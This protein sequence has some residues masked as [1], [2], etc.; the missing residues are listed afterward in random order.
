MVQLTQIADDAPYE[1]K[2]AYELDVELDVEDETLL[3]RVRALQDIIPPSTRLLLYN[4]FASA[5]SYVRSTVATG[6]LYL[7]TVGASVL[8]VGM[9]WAIAIMAE[10][11]Q[12]QLE[13]DLLLQKTA[14]EVI[15]PGLEAAFAD[16]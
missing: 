10:L 3:E 2:P 1:E 13:A 14:Q 15:A 8:L 11:Q 9:P 7:W 4:Q 6:G 5:L 12:Q 16:K